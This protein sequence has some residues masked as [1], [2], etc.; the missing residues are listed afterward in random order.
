MRSFLRYEVKNFLRCEV[1]RLPKVRGVR[2]KL[3]IIAKIENVNPRLQVKYLSDRNT[4]TDQAMYSSRK[5]EN[6]RELN[7]R[8]ERRAIV[9]ETT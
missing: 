3:A 2:L 4:R 9:R 1:R 7:G 8:R 5:E 6:D